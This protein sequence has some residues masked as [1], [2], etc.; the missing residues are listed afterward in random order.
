MSW[1]LLS[2]LNDR[3]REILDLLGL[4]PM[5]RVEYPDDVCTSLLHVV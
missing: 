2:S 4:G 5:L 1:S 3:N